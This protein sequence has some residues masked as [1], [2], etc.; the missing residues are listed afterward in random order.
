MFADELIVWNVSI[1][2]SNDIV[3][4]LKCIGR[5][6]VEFMPSRFC[7]ADNVKP[8]PSPSLTEVRR[9]KELIDNVFD[10]LRVLVLD[11]CFDCIYRWRKTN[12][13]EIQASK[14]CC[15]F[16]IS[17]WLDVSLFKL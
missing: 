11:K 14:E 4:V 3:A 8:V 17:R 15:S 16:R 6:I 9:F 5:V 13:I 1:D 10:C 2:R 7:V 12:Q